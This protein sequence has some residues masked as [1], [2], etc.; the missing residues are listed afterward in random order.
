MTT[1]NGQI[2]IFTSNFGPQHL[3][4]DGTEKLI[5]YKTYLQDLTYFDRLDGDRG[6]TE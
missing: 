6:V 4:V 5:E 1:K 3:V 2:K